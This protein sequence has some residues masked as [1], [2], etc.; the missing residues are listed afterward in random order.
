MGI[1]YKRLFFINQAEFLPNFIA[2][3]RLQ[4][5]IEVPM[6]HHRRFVRFQVSEDE[7]QLIRQN[8]ST[9][10]WLKDISL[11]GLS[12][13]YIAAEKQQVDLEDIGIF[14]DKNKGI[15]LPGLSCKVV[16]DINVDEESETFSV[17][18]FWRRGLKY[19]TLTNGQR[20]R[21]VY[22]LNNNVN[23]KSIETVGETKG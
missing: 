17:C 6:F 15:F 11:H 22:L 19:R 23:D 1:A 5:L 16:Y 2:Q 7:F 20:D 13:E 8:N 14:S 12:Y 18:N 10:G 21:L 3:N 9:I 4:I